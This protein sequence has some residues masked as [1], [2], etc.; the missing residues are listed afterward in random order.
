M[1]NS[2]WFLK[3]DTTTIEGYRSQRSI[4]HILSGIFP[5][6]KQ[7]MSKKSKNSDDNNNNSNNNNNNDDGGNNVVNF[8]TKVTS[9]KIDT[10]NDTSLS[11]PNYEYFNR[12]Q[13]NSDISSSEGRINFM[14]GGGGGNDD[15]DDD[16]SGCPYHTNN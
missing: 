9:N 16:D 6:L 7:I 4:H 8:A 2:V 13:R 14:G 15:D 5:S 11:P 12:P 10:T 1:P 3:K